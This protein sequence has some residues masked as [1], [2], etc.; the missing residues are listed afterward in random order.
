MCAV[1]WFGYHVAALLRISLGRG[2]EWGGGGGWS[3][4][5]GREGIINTFKYHIYRLN[6]KTCGF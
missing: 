1:R 6:S 3:V 2:G 4:V 5:C